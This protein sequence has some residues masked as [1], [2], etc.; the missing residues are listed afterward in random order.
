M[1]KNKSEAATFVRGQGQPPRRGEI[2]NRPVIRQF[3]DHTRQ[4]AAFERFFHRP[5]GIARTGN[6]EEQKPPC[7]QTEKIAAKAIDV[8]ALAGGKIRL[9]PKRIATVIGGARRQSKC[10]AH[11]RA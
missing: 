2:G 1:T 11:G 4:G 6:L 5:Q 7:R 3:G 9:N 10:Q 8:A